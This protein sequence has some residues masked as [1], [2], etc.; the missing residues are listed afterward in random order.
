MANAGVEGVG[1]EQQTATA[2][3][4]G[5][6]RKRIGFSTMILLLVIDKSITVLLVRSKRMLRLRIHRPF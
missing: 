5:G 2:K 6:R 3:R 4:V 1:A